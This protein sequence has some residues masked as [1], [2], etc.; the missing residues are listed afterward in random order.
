MIT[1]KATAPN[2]DIGI[3]TIKSGIVC[4]RVVGPLDCPEGNALGLALMNAEKL[5]AL[6]TCKAFLPDFQ[7]TRRAFPR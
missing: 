5:T 2:G 6:M 7:F 4:F 3:I 1:I